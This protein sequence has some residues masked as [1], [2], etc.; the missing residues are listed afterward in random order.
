MYEPTKWENHVTEPKNRFKLRHIEGDEYE[1]VP[2]G[3]IVNRGTLLCAENF[4]KSETAVSE[5]TTALG[6]LLQTVLLDRDRLPESFYLT[7][8]R[9]ISNDRYGS[10]NVAVLGWV[11]FDEARK[12]ADYLV[13]PIITNVEIFTT[14]DQGHTPTH[15]VSTPTISIGEKTSTRLYYNVFRG[16]KGSDF[17]SMT[18][19]FLIIGGI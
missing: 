2:C 17:K 14:Q 10:E 9:T 8:E 3:D 15:Q 18:Y 12:N 7:E 1:I 11:D 5:V 6:C 4:N 19:R 16:M 13:V